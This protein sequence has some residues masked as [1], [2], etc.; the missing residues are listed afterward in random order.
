MDFLFLNHMV[1]AY[2]ITE[3]NQPQAASFSLKHYGLVTQIKLKKN[4]SWIHTW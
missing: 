3:L 2:D 4:I 1:H